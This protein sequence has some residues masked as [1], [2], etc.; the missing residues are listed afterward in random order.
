MNN[1]Q[2]FNERYMAIRQQAAL[3]L[4]LW[5]IGRDHFTALLYGLMAKADQSNRS[6]LRLVF[7]IESEIFDEWQA[8]KNEEEFFRK[9]GV[10]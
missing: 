5:Q 3:D 9:W 10:A 1:P 6:R 2:Q 4:K 8:S 7:P